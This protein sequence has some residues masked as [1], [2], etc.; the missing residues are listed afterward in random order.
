MY[1]LVPTTRRCIAHGFLNLCLGLKLYI[2]LHLPVQSQSIPLC[3]LY[4][5]A[6]VLVVVA[7]STLC[8]ASGKETLACLA[9]CTLREGSNALAYI[10]GGAAP[11]TPPREE[12]DLLQ[13]NRS[14]NSLLLRAAEIDGPTTNLPGVSN[15]LQMAITESDGR[16]PNR[17]CFYVSDDFALPAMD[18]L[19]LA[20][21]ST[22]RL[23]FMFAAPAS[24][25]RKGM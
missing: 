23:I 7:K 14:A 1:I 25:K 15:C 17:G 8:L 24:R 21:S 6:Q 19:E 11:P 20:E 2:V 4:I 5:L 10:S 12:G 16:S 22:R 3:M 9:A 13:H 18:T